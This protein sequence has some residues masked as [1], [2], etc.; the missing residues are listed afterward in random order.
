MFK[1]HEDLFHIIGS[2]ADTG[3]LYVDHCPGGVLPAQDDT[4]S[5][6]RKLNTVIDKIN[7][8]LFYA[9]L[10]TDKFTYCL[11]DMCRKG[12]ALFF[13]KRPYVIDTLSIVLSD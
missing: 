2:D 5:L 11:I 6:L 9:P 3:I 4:P 10:I 13:G 1:R 7:E 8:G 12:K